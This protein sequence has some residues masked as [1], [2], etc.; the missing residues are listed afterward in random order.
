MLKKITSLDGTKMLS[1]KEQEQIKGQLNFPVP[2][3]CN[4]V[5]CPN[6][7]HCIPGYNA[8][9]VFTSGRIQGQYCVAL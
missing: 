6:G 5:Y 8:H 4:G 9:C 3:N 7:C 2:L 1:K